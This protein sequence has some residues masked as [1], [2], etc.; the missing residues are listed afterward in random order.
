MV[1]D[2]IFPFP[3]FFVFFTQLVVNEHW[4][5]LESF[6]IVCELDKWRWG[7]E[8]WSPFVFH[9]LLK[10]P[11]W[12][13]QL[14]WNSFERSSSRYSVVNSQLKNCLYVR[15]G[16]RLA[17]VHPTLLRDWVNLNRAIKAFHDFLAWINVIFT[18][19]KISRTAIWEA[20]QSLLFSHYKTCRHT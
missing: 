13:F 11:N 19:W 15:W 5:S 20:T 18:H 8:I 14:W 1:N 3:T 7:F 9:N 2:L 6:S 10:G 17:D 12:T 4:A 16:F